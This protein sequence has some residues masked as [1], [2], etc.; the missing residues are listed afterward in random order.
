MKANIK[1]AVKIKTQKA[2]GIVHG[3]PHIIGYYNG[4]K[5]YNKMRNF[6]GE[7]SHII[8]RNEHEA[9]KNTKYPCFA[10]P[11]PTVPRH[12]FVD[13][14]TVTTRKELMKLWKEV[15]N[16]DAKGEIILGPHIKN[17]ISNAVYIS[18]GNM[19]IG[20]GNDGATGGKGSISFPVA[21]HSFAAK[22]MQKSGLTRDDTVYLE[23]ILTKGQWWLTQVR[24]GPAINAVSPDYIPKSTKVKEVVYPHD[25]LLAWESEA[26]NF[27]PGTVV[28]GNG[29]TLASHAAIHC[30]LNK[31]PFVTTFR[32]VVG[33]TI[34][35]V[36]ATKTRKLNRTRFK[37]G[38]RAGLNICKTRTGNLNMLRFFYF[39]LSV[40]HNWAYLKHSEHADW[41]LGAATM[42]FAKISASLVHGEFRHSQ[43]YNNKYICRSNVY[44]K[45]LNASSSVFS[46][47]PMIFNDFYAGQWSG[48]FGGI[49]WANCTWYTYSL[50]TNIAKAYNKTSVNLTEKEI[51]DIISTVNRTVNVAHNNGWWFNKIVKQDNMDFIAKSPG[52]AAYCVSE[53]YDELYKKMQ[54]V[55]SVTR[56]FKDPIKLASPF[57]KDKDGRL[58]WIYLN[59]AR[60]KTSLSVL[61]E[62]GKRKQKNIKLSKKELVATKKFY[63]SEDK[64]YWSRT[65]LPTNAK[66]QFK[67]PGG[68]FR[69]IGKVF[70]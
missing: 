10:R 67:I 28:Y 11:C 22:I 5:A 59:S 50:W 19:A 41:L 40:L 43:K 36:K 60:P 58:A 64:C 53:L 23:S 16:Q 17:I 26:K 15:I 38:A 62:D 49:P 65:L 68:V 47:L 44:V 42:L 8:I 1:M 70:A 31:I 12:G 7:P 54:K 33:K 39:S 13:S 25:D 20:K 21:P 51:S 24:G 9:I 63:E 35:P 52:L 6:L 61:F 32:P 2:K 48:G 55:T 34:K 46:E 57:T 14:R 66:G 37:R 30:V 27:K 18:S 69:D 29:H 56:K 4:G 3:I 45:T